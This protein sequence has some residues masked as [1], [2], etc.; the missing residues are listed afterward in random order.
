MQLTTATNYLT[1]GNITAL[2]SKTWRHTLPRDMSGYTASGEVSSET[3]EGDWDELFALA[4]TWLASATT[5]LQIAVSLSSKQT[6][7]QSTLTVTRSVY[8]SN[9]ELFSSS[10]SAEAV[11]K[12]ASC[13]SYTTEVSEVEASILTCPL[14]TSKNY[15][16][17]TLAALQHICKGGSEFDS[18]YVSSGIASEVVHLL[19]SDSDV[20]ELVRS[21][22]SFLD[23]RVVHSV[24]WETAVAVDV[25][26]GAMTVQTPPTAP[27]YPGREWLYVGGS[28]TND[29]SVTRV[30]KKYW[31][32]GPGGWSKIYG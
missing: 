18:I 4:Q 1:R 10:N 16:Q 25:M 24:T 28:L 14:I 29:G 32:S 2:Q 8:V 9:E 23:A 21:Q 22:E 11:G 27:S 26:N 15:D 5:N 30:T 12:T 20:I 31:L 13:P 17:D 3:W 19:P 7:K 6:A